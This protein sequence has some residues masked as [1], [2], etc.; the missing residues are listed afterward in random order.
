MKKIISILVLL[1]VSIVLQAQV[2]FI[3]STDNFVNSNDNYSLMPLTQKVQHIGF[4]QK[5]I[6]SQLNNSTMQRFYLTLGGY[7]STISVKEING[8]YI[9]DFEM[10]GND[11]VYF[12]GSYG[13][14]GFVASVNIY[15]LFWNPN[16]YPN[17]IK[18]RQF[19]NTDTIKKI[20]LYYDQNQ[21]TRKIV[22]I[23]GYIDSL[24][25][26]YNCFIDIT[27]PL[28][29]NEISH[30]YYVNDTNIKFQN[31][32]CTDNYVYV[33]GIDS[34]FPNQNLTI[35]RF[36]KYNISN[37]QTQIKY[38]AGIHPT[39]SIYD[40]F[41]TEQMT[42]DTIAVSTVFLTN[43]TYSS[44]HAGIMKI[45][46]NSLRMSNI[47]LFNNTQQG[48]SIYD[49]AYY[50]KN[51][52]LLV[53]G[54]KIYDPLSL[55]FNAEATYFIDMNDYPINLQYNSI[56]VGTIQYKEFRY[57]T[58]E[59][60]EDDYYI[61]AGVNTGD[62]SLLTF[63]KDPNDKDPV[64][65]CEPIEPFV[66]NIVPALIPDKTLPLVSGDSSF[67]NFYLSTDNYINHYNN[68]ICKTNKG[69]PVN[70]YNYSN[71]EIQL[72]PNP[73]Q[74][75]FEILS[76]KDIISIEIC[77]VLGAIIYNQ[78]INNKSARIDTEQLV[79]GIYFIK[80]N[81]KEEIITKKLI[82]E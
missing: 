2:P 65:N 25:V 14:A 53:L 55:P 26:K 75:Y 4:S 62:N 6:L 54:E 59:I 46:L 48:Q 23:G 18:I 80:L 82:I 72:F 20:K 34:K 51:N 13:N 12:C 30:L 57:S 22:G 28:N 10:F 56:L 3:T 11:S 61:L 15:D 9:S 49:M 70:P 36:N 32:N 52:Q 19:N 69:I 73:A 67:Y 33:L 60:C 42:G 76:K 39:F 81:T 24:G 37:G 47:M 79:K 21:T 64:K 29:S 16:G 5:I 77:N 8:C 58:I 7:A 78:S 50:K 44:F 17:P 38:I 68:N 31:I 27:V 35:H 63:T 45:D 71:E 43:K 66:V 41:K 74:S 40:S 1:V